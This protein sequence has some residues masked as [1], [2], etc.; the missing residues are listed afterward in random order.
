ML[1]LKNIFI[2]IGIYILDF[3]KGNPLVS[4]KGNDLLKKRFVLR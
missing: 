4:Y 1:I 3:F 2:F